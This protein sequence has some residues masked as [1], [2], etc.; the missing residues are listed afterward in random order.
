MTQSDSYSAGDFTWNM[1]TP[2][3]PQA[4]DPRAAREQ[5]VSEASILKQ[6][7]LGGPEVQRV[8]ATAVDQG[9]DLG[10]DESLQD[11]SLPYLQFA[12]RHG[13]QLAQERYR[14]GMAQGDLDEL[15]S[16]E[17]TFGGTVQDSAIDFGLAATN[18]VGGAAALGVNVIDQVGDTTMSPMISQ[19]LSW[20]NERGREAQTPLMQERLAQH[21]LEAE[22][23]RQDREARYEQR[24]EDSAGGATE[25][26]REIQPWVQKMGEAFGETITNYGNDPIMQ[27]AL[28]PEAL[29]SLVPATATIR[30]LALARASSVLAGQGVAQ[31][32][33]R[34]QLRTAEG[35]RLVDQQA[36]AVA[37]M[38]ITIMESGA[39]V[40]QAQQGI[41]A[42]TEED[43]ADNP[44]YAALREQGLDHDGAQMEL[45]R[46]AGSVAGVTAAP[47]ALAAGRIASSFAANPFRTGPG[48]VVTGALQ[49]VTRETIEETL[50]EANSTLASNL[51]QNIAGGQE[52][53]LDEGVAEGA[54]QGA[55]GGMIASGVMQSPGLAVRT[56]QELGSLGA[57]GVRTAVAARRAS[58]DRRD[59]ARSTVGTTAQET[60][61][62]E[63]GAIGQE[64]L[65]GLG[66]TTPVAGAVADPTEAQNTE[67]QNT[68]ADPITPVA[69]TAPIISE[70]ST[71]EAG[72]EA[73]A[74]VDV[75]TQI[76]G[77]LFLAPAEVSAYSED[78]R[79]AEEVSRLRQDNPEAPITRAQMINIAGRPLMDPKVPIEAKIGTALGL[80]SEFDAM[81]SLD[82]TNIRQRVDALPENDG[83][84]VAYQKLDQHLQVL[85][86]SAVIRKAREAIATLTPETVRQY[87][88][89][90]ELR[91]PNLKDE[92]RAAI[93]AGMETV[94]RINPEAIKETDYDLVLNQ[95]GTGKQASFLK[96][97]LNL[98]RIIANEFRFSRTTKTE[99]LEDQDA[100]I[101]AFG[102]T[103]GPKQGR[104]HKTTDIVQQEIRTL[105]NSN[106]NLPSLE[107]HR[108]R[109]IEAGRVGRVE[110]T[111]DA[112]DQL[113]GFAQSQIN[114][115]AA[116]NESVA[117]GVGRKSR[118]SFEAYNGSE[119]FLDEN[120]VYA[121]IGSPASVAMVREAFADTQTAVAMVN[122]L[123]EAYD[124]ETSAALVV[125]KMDARIL[126]AGKKAD[127]KAVA[128]IKEETTEIKSPV[129][130][131]VV[132]VETEPDPTTPEQTTPDQTE[133]ETE[134]EPEASSEGPVDTTSAAEQSEEVSEGSVDDETQE[135]IEEEAEPVLIDEEVEETAEALN[136]S[137]VKTWFDS[138]NDVLLKT[139]DGFN[140]FLN[141]FKPKSSTAS[142]VSH[143][144]PVAYVLENMDNLQTETNSLKRD[145]RE[146]EQEAL[147]KFLTGLYPTFRDEFATRANDTREWL[148]GLKTNPITDLSKALR[149]PN[150]LP[151]NFVA[152][153]LETTGDVWI[154]ERIMAATFMATF[155]WMLTNAGPRPRLDDDKVNK[156]FGRPRGTYVTEDM[157]A[158]A[159]YGPQL[160]QALE[161]IATGIERLL[162]VSA[163]K[164]V[165]IEQTQGLF[166][167]MASNALAILEDDKIIESRALG[168]LQDTPK[169]LR[170]RKVLR[171]AKKYRDDADMKALKD[172]GD[173]FT[174][175]FTDGQDK[176]KDIGEAPKRVAET[177]MKNELA[178]LSKDEKQVVRRLQNMPSFV[179]TPMVDFVE[180]L[181]GQ[182]YKRMLGQKQLSMTELKTMNQEH[183]KSVEGKNQS[184]DYGLEGS[185]SYVNEARAYGEAND[186][187]MALNEVPIFHKWDVSSV[188][189]LQQGGPITPQ[190]DKIAREIISATNATLDLNNAKH[191]KFMW[192]AIAQSLDLKVEKGDPLKTIE[193]AR[194]MLVDPKGLGAAK[195]LVRGWLRTGELD[196]AA[197]EA[198]VMAAG[199]SPT[200]KL[201]HA[202]LTAARME[203]AQQKGGTAYSEFKT[204]LALEADGKTDGPV[205]A[206][207]HMGIGEFLASEIERFAKGGLYFTNQ[208]ISLNEFIELESKKFGTKKKYGEDLYH[209]AAS[210]F[211]RKLRSG[212]T[213]RAPV[214]ISTI[215][216]VS[217][218]L[219]GFTLGKMDENGIVDPFEPDVGRN[220]VKNPLT[221]F[222][223]GSGVSGIAGKIAKE[224]VEKIYITLSE[225]KV[226]GELW[227]VHDTF[228]ENPDLMKDMI[229]VMG[230]D[231][232]ARLFKDPT[233]AKISKEEFEAL[234]MQVELH[235]TD[236]MMDAVKELTGDLRDNM[237]L[238][239]KASQIQTLIFQ[240]EF[241][242]R[243]EEKTKAQLEKARKQHEKSGSKEEFKR[244]RGDLLTQNEIMDIFIETMKIAPIYGS[245][246]QSFHISSPKRDSTD[247]DVVE[248]TVAS[249]FMGSLNKARATYIQP[250]DASVKVSAYMTIGTGDG[251]MILNIY[252]KADGSLDVSLPVF[253]GVEMAVSEIESASRQINEGVF[254]GWMD[255]NIYANLRDGFEQ[256]TSWLVE[257]RFEALDKETKTELAKTLGVKEKNLDFRHIGQM[258]AQLEYM[259]IESQARKF[260]M[261]K[262]ASST[263]HMAGIEAVFQHEGEITPSNDPLAYQEIA[264][265]LNKWRTQEVTRLEAE[266]KARKEGPE[267]ERPI[268]LS[269]DN[270]TEDFDDY[271][272]P[273]QKVARKEEG[274]AQAPTEGMRNLI[275]EIGEVVPGYDGIRKIRGDQLLPFLSESTEA[276]A[277]QIALF[278]DVLMKD[279]KFKGFSY[280]F[281]TSA[282]LTDFRDA[283]NLLPENAP[284]N[285]VELG[286]TL[287]GQG[288]VL[289]AN[290]SPETLL[291]EML[292]THTAT[293]V[294]NHYRDPSASPQHVQ[295]AV[296][297]LEELMD[298]VLELRPDSQ[299]LLV[300]QNQLTSLSHKQAAR[301]T[302]FISYMLSNQTLIE[303]GQKTKTYRPLMDIVKKGLD[304]LKK[305]LGIKNLK[306]GTT[307]FSNIEF[308][309]RILLAENPVMAAAEA[310]ASVDEVLDQVYGE[311]PRLSRI[312]ARFLG[313]LRGI[314]ARG[315]N[316]IEKAEDKAA[317]L[318]ALRKSRKAS[319]MA[320]RKGYQMNARQ[321]RAFEA[322]H[323]TLLAGMKINPE[324]A[325]RTNEAYSH[326]V[327]NL[328]TEDFPDQTRAEGQRGFLVGAGGR[329]N[330]GDNRSDLLATF[331]A[332][333]LVD[334]ELRAVLGEMKSPKVVDI[335]WNSID[336]VL[337]SIGAAAVN[338]LTRLSLNPQRPAKNIQAELDQLGD[339][340]TEVQ[341]KRRYMAALEQVNDRLETANKYM[342][343]KL[344]T[345]SESAVKA[346]DERS[347]RTQYKAVKAT[348]DVAGFVT[349]MGSK[350][351][352]TDKGA[353]L[354]TMMNHVDGWN[355]ARSFLADLQGAN[356]NNIELLRLINRAKAEIDQLRQDFREGVPRELTAQFSRR[357][358]KEEWAAFHTGLGKADLL[359]LG[360]SGARGLMA[361]PGRVSSL[362]QQEEAKLAKLGGAFTS[363]YQAKAKALAIWMV[364]QEVT[365][366]NLLRNAETIAYLAAEGNSFKETRDIENLVDQSKGDLVA[367]IDKLT[368]LY[369]YRELDPSTKALLKTLAETE[370][371]G[372]ETIVGFHDSTRRME[373]ERNG[374]NRTSKEARMNGWKGYVP[375]HSSPGASVI[376]EDDT[377][378]AKLARKGYVRIGNFLGDGDEG[379]RGK[380]GYYQ[381]TVAG[382]VGYRQGVAQTVHETWMGVDVRNG[383]TMSGKMGGTVGG[384]KAKRIAHAR[385]GAPKGSLDGLAPA[386]RLIPVLNAK[387]EVVRYERAMDPSMLTG[388][389]T[390]THH[391]RMLGSWVGRIFEENQADKINQELVT[392]MKGIYD[393]A[394]QS[395]DTT[396][397]VNLA[398]KNQKDPVYKDTWNT[399]GFRIK[400]EIAEAF[401]EENFFPVRKEMVEDAVGYRRASLTDAWTGVSRFSPENQARVRDFSELLTGTKGFGWLTNAEQVLDT[402]VSYAKT[403]IIVRSMVVPMANIASNV[404][405]LLMRGVGFMKILTSGRRKFLEITTYVKNREEIQKLQVR[406][407][408]ATQD[409]R[410]SQDIKARITA[411]RDANDRLSIK[412]LLDA[413]EFSTIAEDL[414][415]ADVAIREGTMEAWINKAIE[416]LPG[417]GT[418]AAN[419]L[420]ITKDTALFQGLNR[421]VQYGDFVAK[422][423][424]YD[425][426]MAQGV[427]EEFTE[428]RNTNPSRKDLIG[429]IKGVNSARLETASN[430]QLD[431]VDDALISEMGDISVLMDLLEIP[432]EKGPVSKTP[433]E[434]DI[435]VTQERLLEIYQEV[436]ESPEAFETFKPELTELLGWLTIDPSQTDNKDRKARAEKGANK[437][438]N[439]NLKAHYLIQTIEELG[440]VLSERDR[441]AGVDNTS[442]SQDLEIQKRAMKVL[443]FGPG[444][445]NK[446]TGP[447]EGK[448]NLEAY[449]MAAG[450]KGNSQGGTKK[451]GQAKMSQRE[452]LDVIMEEFVQYNRLPGRGRDFLESIGVMW[453]WNYKLR[454]QK[455]VMSTIRER[456]LN[457]LLLMAGGGPATGI[458]SVWDGSL[459]GNISDGSLGYSLGPSM[460]LNSGALHPGA[461]L[462][463]A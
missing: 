10:Q 264:D 445:V 388:L 262:L 334:P 241:S 326:V 423:V 375:E 189:R 154:E 72:T 456:P 30:A 371:N 348:L 251:R 68:E 67:A 73:E 123:A 227:R 96:K 197:F 420:L 36:V 352:S 448:T 290:Q 119:M 155:E 323:T 397:F 231:V 16:R 136:Q 11:L 186:R 313:H 330:A 28:V 61:A 65:S 339:I 389:Q 75:K 366:D 414:D 406:L 351:A 238:T 183:R 1:G 118:V 402:G 22:L 223:Y 12:A 421:M 83:T 84:R 410:R 286:Q 321:A 277:E 41:L 312:E 294:I 243:L 69:P 54:A 346:L 114:K 383:Q 418:T 380:R 300:V 89:I 21:Q 35:R 219:E 120:G 342:G 401:G 302:E 128:K 162:G 358:T 285:P 130:D 263:H 461:Q 429:V 131:A 105:G 341:S 226:S 319:E 224:M 74:E 372:V 415:Q 246:S 170:N 458:D 237:E 215:G 201:I 79:I 327:Q 305:L 37:P 99:I 70:Q 144:D 398:D 295:I 133:T 167:A 411:L 127:K 280:Y 85:E 111:Y 345:A 314:I 194:R 4:Q 27:G 320:V 374:T 220:V 50:Q 232:V 254:R 370:A 23:D 256:L 169:G 29:G 81:R 214:M 413:G 357:L 332:L 6:A 110:D 284:R 157:A 195:D 433:L 101:E 66:E 121:E 426:L 9:N 38:V 15:R 318:M 34:T 274:Y 95:V 145:L 454:I 452:A 230:Q 449:N 106:N 51:G 39:A 202:I 107:E 92:D 173:P 459:A 40:N 71:T 393:K 137:P 407:G 462:F 97:S 324:L 126:R 77:N 412:P 58:I 19:G 209:L 117:L 32:A 115:S 44:Q 31:G 198:A 88:P 283:E 49:N 260:A 281:G 140:V 236:P 5:R 8:I 338:I 52:I 417:W 386:E 376:V 361:D 26:S 391:G 240:D 192:L 222:L 190:G 446:G 78:V 316:V 63:V 148:A 146:Q 172:I 396:G 297:R 381:S 134:T 193:E 439:G 424:L 444:T 363:R 102:S 293:I 203:E 460:G 390:D 278:W 322:I 436:K 336:N 440:E 234:R 207:I 225:V 205:N 7:I 315:T 182:T 80:M 427:E 329:R 100:V 378:S 438:G 184:L 268:E 403:T 122:A 404:M 176:K 265:L 355:T 333:S 212:M 399:L 328:K 244:K 59:D 113:R 431:Q 422:A 349:A 213:S 221:I 248:H 90:D 112:W 48:N 428:V 109:I 87:L 356:P 430:E 432:Y 282:E 455:I 91:N 247:S 45:A 360:Q 457:A 76:L 298:D 408:A 13:D 217:G 276:T 451:K 289:V 270:L 93:L 174:M 3:E 453:F 164:D 218:L 377:K 335:Q 242:K 125:P 343:G 24:L 288:V 147:T 395:G 400:E 14:F 166:R 33:I 367:T 359:A 2:V 94:G 228:M 291:H 142:L 301:M 369:A 252:T 139:T 82:S 20:L 317:V 437:Y 261:N 188:G 385:A 419:N 47:G 156:F 387:M 350:E 373:I 216:M 443:R 310:D 233:K 299:A 337:R 296:Q 143:A 160:Q 178:L 56:A 307:L 158:M 379:Y 331:V 425:H 185:L 86:Q 151:F 98:A 153:Q 463:G 17:R 62:T 245:E 138:L 353:A 405:Q 273:D 57:D 103:A 394:I 340:L 116:Y 249:T 135:E 272:K 434:Q 229:S 253:D 442:R 239:Q 206:M 311:D 177:Q 179:N 64:I 287:V 267:S 269:D 365:S 271:L 149:F 175:I 108:R 25:W 200:P 152:G 141:A 165:S 266:L 362:I 210:L 309:T 344:K 159:Q 416:K 303:K 199:V 211:E 187:G 180:A 275:Q 308:S 435:L 181:G 447:Y 384:S 161:Q 292:H 409:P 124:I 129:E 382:M 392:T 364:R 354:M 208:A 204:A 306:P 441:L 150:G 255:G 250:S 258:Q 42:L 168:E 171:V 60:A 196:G 132:V 46:N 43:F 257:E 163:N 104:K 259:A 450:K 368:S 18:L 304:L 53:A 279:G 347:R 55:L 325:R 191:Q 235:F